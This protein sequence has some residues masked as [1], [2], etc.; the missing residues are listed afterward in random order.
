MVGSMAGGG[1]PVVVVVDLAM[2]IEGLGMITLVN[3]KWV[4]GMVMLM[5]GLMVDF[6]LVGFL[7]V[8][9]IGNL[10]VVVMATLQMQGIFREKD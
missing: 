4:A 10:G 8:H 5:T 6:D 2:V 3:A 1:A 9:L 7:V